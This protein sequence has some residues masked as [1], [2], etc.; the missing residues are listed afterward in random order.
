M[1][2]GSSFAAAGGARRGDGISFGMAGPRVAAWKDISADVE[3]PVSAY[4]K[5]RRP[6]YGFLFESVEGG[7]RVGRYSFLGSGPVATFEA[8]GRSLV[9][10]RDGRKRVIPGDPF[11]A[12]RRV[13]R[14]G[15]SVVPGRPRFEGGLVGYIGYDAVRHVERLPRPP[16]DDLGLPDIMMMLQETVLVFDHVR[17]VIRIISHANRKG[18]DRAAREKAVSSIREVE[19]M[20]ARPTT[21][22]IGM[23]LGRLEPP[24]SF[25]ANISR[26]RFLANVRRAKRH[27]VAGDVIQVVLSQRL[28]APYTRD[29]FLLY[30]SLRVLNPSPYMFFLE[31]GKASLAGSSP[32]LL[33]RVEGDF[34]EARPIAGTRPRG[35][36]AASDLA[37]ERELRA[38][39]KELAEHVMLVD[40]G[41]N[42]LGRVCRFGSVEV[43]ESMVVER[44]SH[45][46]HLVTGVR[47]RLARGRDAYDVLRACFPAGTVS[48]A[49]KVR[50]MEIIDEL[51]PTRRGPY[52]GAAGYVGFSGNLD[53]AIAIRTILVS[54]GMAHVQAGMGIVADSDPAAEYRESLAKA[55]AALL[56]VAAAGTDAGKPAR[57]GRAS[58]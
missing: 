56:A 52:A 42:D 24:R 21:G 1:K 20:L 19:A 50:A 16:R 48:G 41:R 28:S 34:V 58:A 11:E 6:P 26:P 49:P 37:L 17:H 30:R 9:E 47:G 51:E 22:A 29:P 12:L 13:F 33:V 3:T 36:D 18:G 35:R 40:L 45:V 7:E 14:P 39:P 54:G 2:P 38:D 5:V 8:R 25:R 46:M 57:G 55:R 53:T 27:I 4:L 15:P 23:A 31:C 44:Y 10:T 32:E 43:S